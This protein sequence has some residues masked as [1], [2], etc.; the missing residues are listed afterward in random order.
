MNKE[1]QVLGG[2]LELTGKFEEIKKGVIIMIIRKILV[3]TSVLILLVLVLSFTVIG[4]G[5]LSEEKIKA[6]ATK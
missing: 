4:K 2:N 5:W 1:S 3:I 6:I